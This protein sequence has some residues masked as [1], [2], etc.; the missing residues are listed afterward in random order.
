MEK[1]DPTYLT[2]ELLLFTSNRLLIAA[3]RGDIKNFAAQKSPLT[4]ESCL[5][6]LRSYAQWDRH[7]TVLGCE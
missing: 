5:Y 7:C 3:I 6:G 2:E 4:P 1:R